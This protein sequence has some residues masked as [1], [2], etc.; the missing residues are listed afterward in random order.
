MTAHASRTI[1][2]LGCAA[3]VLAVVQACSGEPRKA[4]APPAKIDAGAP[5]GEQGCIC[6]PHA[7]CPSCPD[8]RS[9]CSDWPVSVNCTPEPCKTDMDCST[10]FCDKGFCGPLRTG[11]LPNGSACKAD[12]DCE[13]GL[14]DR[15][16][17]MDIGAPRSLS[18]GE[19]C[20]PLPPMAQRSGRL[21]DPCGGYICLDGRCRS[22]ISNEECRNWKGGDSTCDHNIGLPGNSCGRFFPLS[23]NSPYRNPPVLPPDPPLEE[24]CVCPPEPPCPPC[25]APTSTCYDPGTSANCMMG[26]CTTDK[27]CSPGFCNRDICGL[28]RRGHAYNGTECKTDDYCQSLLCDRGVCADIGGPRNGHHGEP[29]RP[30]PP[31]ARRAGR[32]DDPCGGYICLDGSCRSCV[33][34]AECTY[35]KGGGTCDYHP[36]LPGQRCSGYPPRDSAGPPKPPAAVP[37]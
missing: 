18:H 9:P 5:P 35:W 6:P 21:E 1:A 13:S 3:F 4:I 29:C 19:A 17:C 30:L 2:V 8:P 22:C 26:I 20:D 11:N 36:G 32:S 33:S 24:V 12:H 7:P 15:D 16:I 27:D 37:R 23:P 28:V 14:C 10:R 34:D 25:P 31:F